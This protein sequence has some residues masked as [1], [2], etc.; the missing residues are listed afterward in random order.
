MN[1]RAILRRTVAVV[2]GG[3]LLA[4]VVPSDEAQARG[5][6]RGLPGTWFYQVPSG[7]TGFNTYHQDGTVTGVT[8]TI[9]GAP[10]HPGGA[11]TWASADHGTWRRV[12]H[13][14]E[15]A[16]Y[17]ILFDPATGDPT[18]ITRIR[19]F[20]SFDPDR[21]STSGTFLVDQWYCPDALSCP[22]PNTAPPDV[23]GIS[24]PPPFN[25]VTQSRV[26]MP[27]RGR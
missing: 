8:S 22:D 16:A 26:R 12:G 5:G 14:F 17:R 18:T 19:T 1:R 7:R 2:A 21:D 24:P 20:F 27:R 25:T 6:S 4:T 9:F 10:P 3:L 23:E 13:G 15:A 11:A